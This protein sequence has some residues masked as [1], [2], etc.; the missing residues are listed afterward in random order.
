MEVRKGSKVNLFMACL[1]GIREK[2]QEGGGRGETEGEK[3]REAKLRRTGEERVLIFILEC[4]H[5]E[6][7]SLHLTHF[8]M[9]HF[10]T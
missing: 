10:G 5:W 8:V 1:F 2:G 3:E 4:L 6:Y 7:V 9:S